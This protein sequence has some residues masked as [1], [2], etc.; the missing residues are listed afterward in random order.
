M[1]PHQKSSKSAYHSGLLKLLHKQQ[2]EG[3]DV[4]IKLQSDKKTIAVHSVILKSGSPFLASLLGSP[5]SC[6]QPDTLVLHP[7]YCEVLPHLVSLLYTGYSKHE[8]K[9]QRTLLQSFIKDL[10]FKN[11]VYESHYPRKAFK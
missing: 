6:S 8:N 9:S 2:K 1:M 11:V 4:D 7:L 3:V 5:C 10:G